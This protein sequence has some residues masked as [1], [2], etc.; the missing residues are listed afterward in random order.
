M[1]WKTSCCLFIRVHEIV[2]SRISF[3]ARLAFLHAPKTTLY[4]TQT[5]VRTAGC[6]ISKMIDLMVMQGCL[7]YIEV[8]GYTYG[9]HGDD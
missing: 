5:A 6:S 9:M 4:T 7:M 3:H 8:L 1:E 2:C